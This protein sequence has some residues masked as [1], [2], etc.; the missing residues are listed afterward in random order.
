MV[1]RIACGQVRY[2]V[3]RRYTVSGRNIGHLKLKTPLRLQPQ[4]ASV[5]A[6][7]M[8]TKFHFVYIVLC[9]VYI[10]VCNKRRQINRSVT[11]RAVIFSNHKPKYCCSTAYRTMN[12]VIFVHI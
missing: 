5:R 11:V 3:R 4:N 10:C 7:A 6:K 2:M 1:H 8:E 9:D 12:A